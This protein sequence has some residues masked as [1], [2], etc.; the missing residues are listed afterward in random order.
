LR[1]LFFGGGPKRGGKKGRLSSIYLINWG[2]K[3]AKKGGFWGV[4]EKFRFGILGGVFGKKTPKKGG[5]R[6]GPCLGREGIYSP[7]IGIRGGPKGGII[8]PL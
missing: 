2:Q 4:R 3:R 8:N 5:S 1:T 6:E 7:Q